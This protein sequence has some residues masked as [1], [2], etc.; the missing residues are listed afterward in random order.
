MGAQKKAGANRLAGYRTVGF[1]YIA[2]GQR[3]SCP[4]SDDG[5][6]W[7]S[8]QAIAGSRSL[9]DAPNRKRLGSYQQ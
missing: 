2:E 6:F 3:L 4:Y 5:E 7:A 9:F 1:A 8:E